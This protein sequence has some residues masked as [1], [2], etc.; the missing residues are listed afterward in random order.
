MAEPSVIPE[1]K[2]IRQRVYL[3]G[4]VDNVKPEDIEQRLKPFGT[5]SDLCISYDSTGEWC[6]GFAHATLDITD[7]NWQRCVTTLNGAKWKDKKLR[8]EKAKDDYMKRRETELAMM[9]EQERKQMK[10]FK[11]KA[12]VKHATDMSL[13]TDREVE[14]RPGWKRGR[15]GRAIRVMRLRQPDGS[16][17]VY[18]PGM[19]KNNLEK[20]FGSERPLPVEKLTWFYPEQSSEQS[21]KQTNMSDVEQYIEQATS[22][23]ET[24]EDVEMTTEH[25]TEVPS[26]DNNDDDLVIDSNSNTNVEEESTNANEVDTSEEKARSLNIL[27]MMFGESTTAQTTGAITD[28]NEIGRA[29]PNESIE[30]IDLILHPDVPVIPIIDEE[31]TI[32]EENHL[33]QATLSETAMPEHYTV[34]GDLKSMFQLSSQN[35][36]TSNDNAQPFKLFNDPPMEMEAP[37]TFSFDFS[38]MI[39]APATPRIQTTSKPSSTSTTATLPPTFFFA[40]FDQ[41]LLLRRNNIF[42]RTG[43]L[44]DVTKHWEAMRQ[45]LTQDFKQRHKYAIRMRKRQQQTA[46]RSETRH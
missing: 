7:K 8:I 28:S 37:S 44:E 10:Q 5:L 3:S 13:V 42:I 22:E 11:R 9:E 39:G 36:A 27:K 12:L 38:A 25:P 34:K 32:N 20:L 4:L 2:T 33:H 35:N 1:A 16:M 14:A 18:D 40:H 30:F 23:N 21:V 41:P 29:N 43:S 31:P 15:Y 26:D 6:R 24:M 45:G 17:M 46:R 19:Y